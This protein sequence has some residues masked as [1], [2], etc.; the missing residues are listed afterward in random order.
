MHALLLT[1]LIA[2]SPA[3]PAPTYGAQ[4]LPILQQKCLAC[5][6]GA[7]KMGSLVMDTYDTL[8]Q[9][10]AHGP[11]IVPGKGSESRIVLMLEGRLQPRMP[12][13]STPLSPAEIDVIRRW[14]DAGAKGPAPGEALPAPPKVTIPDIKPQVQVVSPVGSIAYSPD[15]KLLAVGGYFEVRLIDAATKKIVA[16]LP[17]HAGLVRSL[18]FS[19]DGKWLAA[20]GGRPMVAGEIKVWD[21][22]TH[23]LLRTLEG[24]TDCIYGVAVSPDGKLVASGSY[25]R[26]AELWDAQTGKELKTL[27]DHIDAVFAVQF[28]PDGKWLA[29]GSQDRTVKIWDVST[30]ERLYTLSDPQDGIASLAFSPTGK[31]I[32][33]AGFD[34]LI[35]VWN[36]DEHGGTLAESLIADEDN[37]LELVWTPD[38]KEIITSSAD[39]SIRI[40][41]S[42][43]LNPLRVFP[44]QS[45]WVEAL[46]ISPS[47]RWLAAGRYDGTVSIY[48]LT[49][50][51]PVGAPLVAFETREPARSAAGSRPDG[52]PD[53]AVKPA[54]E[55]HP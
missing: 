14:I 32:A 12:F 8:R 48:D 52:P 6:S 40:R 47:G 10:G 35:Y 20:A 44:D 43:T 42:A 34:K 50:D 53:R 15:G 7:A 49:N 5:H 46:T 2:A 41:D 16:T 33:A 18:A 29:T 51:Q 9:G 25:D 19:P 17:G 28:S 39:S 1:F 30:G 38:G 37:I 24:H 3:Q 45:D 11:V 31:Q 27:K 23:Q 22:Q 36:L 26:L 55:V 21:V 4:V 54:S 13:N